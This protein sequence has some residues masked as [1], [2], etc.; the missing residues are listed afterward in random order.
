MLLHLLI[1]LSMYHLL[2]LASQ[3]G[4]ELFHCLLRTFTTECYRASTWLLAWIIQPTKLGLVKCL[5]SCFASDVHGVTHTPPQTSLTIAGH[6]AT[7]FK[8]Y[9]ARAEHA[10]EFVSNALPLNLRHLGYSY[11]ESAI[12]RK[13]TV[14]ASVRT[15]LA[16]PSW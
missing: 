3:D 15:P 1:S 4:F 13:C 8:Y 10:L 12:F 2:N 6:L 11:A 9:E 14:S 16:C 5:G 7:T